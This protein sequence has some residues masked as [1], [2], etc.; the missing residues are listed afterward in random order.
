M[1]TRDRNRI[2]EEFFDI[3]SCLLV[4]GTEFMNKIELYDAIKLS[5]QRSVNILY[6]EADNADLESK[7]VR[8]VHG[9]RG[10]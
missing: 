3:V 5:W 10:V 4:E 8:G 9:H 2:H 7:T 1:L 6:K